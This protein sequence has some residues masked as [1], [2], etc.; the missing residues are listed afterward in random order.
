M[1]RKTCLNLIWKICSSSREPSS[2]RRS[3]WCRRYAID[4]VTTKNVSAEVLLLADRLA[5][6]RLIQ[7]SQQLFP[8][9]GLKPEDFAAWENDNSAYRLSKENEILFRLIHNE[10]RRMAH[11]WNDLIDG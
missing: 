7:P 8:K 5:V 1:S 10:D 3:A 2:R 6:P 9:E 4:D 11:L